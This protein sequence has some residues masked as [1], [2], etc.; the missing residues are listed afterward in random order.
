MK[1]NLL[2]MPLLLVITLAISA[3]GCNSEGDLVYQPADLALSCLSSDTIQS[4]TY[5]T[6]PIEKGYSSITIGL[7]LGANASAIC[8][9][10]NVFGLTGTA[11]CPETNSTLPSGGS[12]FPSHA[13]RDPLSFLLLQPQVMSQYASSGSQAAPKLPTTLGYQYR[14]QPNILKDDEGYQF[15]G[16]CISPQFTSRE[17]CSSAGHGET[18]IGLCINPT[19]KAKTACESAGHGELW[20]TDPS[21]PCNGTGGLTDTCSNGYPFGHYVHQ[22]YVDCG[23]AGSNSI[24]GGILDCATKNPGIS[25]WDGTLLGNHGEG[26]WKMVAHRGGTGSNQEVWKDLRTGLTWSSL[27]PS[28]M[29][30]CPASGNNSHCPGNTQSACS[31]FLSPTAGTPISSFAPGEDFIT[32]VYNGA[33]GE[34]GLLSSP[35]V[36]WRLPSMHDIIQAYNDGFPFVFFDATPTN[37]STYIGFWTTYR[38]CSL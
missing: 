16:Y 27:S 24:D 32:G 23:G 26:V 10:K 6:D 4:Q 17:S 31:E 25:T 30:Y 33:K 5:T 19:L 1:K 13:H 8:S 9:G 11:Q 35:S 28:T 12:L 34:M 20:E 7:A 18:W 21:A 15:Y 29:F 3:T 14:S 37:Y 22:K 36:R 38:C 2:I